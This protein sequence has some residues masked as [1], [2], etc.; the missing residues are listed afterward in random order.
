MRLTGDTTLATLAAAEARQAQLAARFPPPGVFHLC[1][2]VDG[3]PVGL[4]TWH[5]K[6][7][8]R[9]TGGQPTAADLARESER[10]AAAETAKD[11]RARAHEA[12]LARPF[13]QEFK[14]ALDTSRKDWA[15]GRPY[16]LL[17]RHS[18]APVQRTTRG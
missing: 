5:L 17:V 10:K 6:P 12:T 16:W 4:A 9:S 7:D 15:K 8:R 11:E 1:A 2:L 3:R 18:P 13:A 14:G